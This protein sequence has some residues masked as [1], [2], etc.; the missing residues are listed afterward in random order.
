VVEEGRVA[1]CLETTNLD[2]VHDSETHSLRR[3]DRTYRERV[4]PARHARTARVGLATYDLEGEPVPFADVEHERF[5]PAG[6]GT[7]WGRPWGT[8]WLRVDGVVPPDWP[9]DGGHEL[10]LDLGFSAAHPGFQAEGLAHDEAGRVLKGVE[11]R[12]R[13]V[14]VVAGPGEPFRVY[15]EMA[16]NPDLGDG[17]SFA[18]TPLGDPAT[19]GDEPLYALGVVELVLPDAEVVAL[20][21]DWRVLR[22]L[23]DALPTATE[24]R[25]RIVQALER[26]VD[27]IDP[28]SGP[29]GPVAGAARAVLAPV[30]A[31]PAAPS[32]HTVTAV[33]HAHIDSAWLWPTRETARKCARTFANV[34]HLMDTEP[35]VVFVASSAQQYAWVQRDHP[36]LFARIAAR[37]AEGR[38][39]PVGGM[40]VEADTNLPGG[41][42]LVRQFLL[43][44]GYFEREL[45]VAVDG[46]DTVWLPDSFGYSAALPQIALGA[47]AGSFL[48]QK[49]SWNDTNRFP[50]STFAWEGI[51]GSRVLTHFPPVDTYNSDLGA[52]DLLRAAAQH[53]EVGRSDESLVPF[54][55]GNGGGGPTR[56]MVEV[57]R[58]KADLEGSPRVRF[59]RPDA[60]FARVREQ[61]PDPPVWSGELYLE[62]HRGTYTSQAR[63][64]LGNR[65]CEHLLREA[66]LW[67]TTATVRTGAAYPVDELR[68]AWET[69]L[70]QQFHDILPGSSI[71]WVHQE[72]ERRYA[73]TVAALEAL[74]ADAIAALG[75]GDAPVSFNASPVVVDGVPPLSAG[76]PDAPAPVT[77]TAVD[78]GAVLESNALRAVL[79]DGGRLV[80]LIDASGREALAPGS[81]GNVL[82]L[83]GDVPNRWDAWDV[84]AAYRRVPRA[85][86]DDHATVRVDG[87]QVLVERSVG[88]G[89]GDPGGRPVPRRH[90]AR[91]DDD[92][93]LAA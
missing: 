45:G 41:E 7:A 76:R 87:A 74:I 92:G 81:A 5:A 89:G 44:R 30:L 48:T 86:A 13:H 71:A 2:V 28:G 33:G 39:V 8:T 93:R 72:A 53:R 46:T 80:S 61:A 68:A 82:E 3:I 65:R 69:V 75:T 36:E 24:R 38:W 16:G 10:V 64:K 26:A 40:W 77:V 54:G 88:G 83:F 51:D 1:A 21:A 4:V 47:G 43:A 57:G 19:A 91:P 67:A 31:S 66:E 52:A 62:F 35:D 63:T 14:P 79:D 37:V 90:R 18:P 15:V 6:V 84:D 17:W 23:V 25:A 73:E 56:E 29:V 42:A 59:D 12:N 70:L 55:W 20:D 22:D 32:V 9:D 50:H 27:A 85:S 34:L 11:P 49:I 78:G 60:F 58:R